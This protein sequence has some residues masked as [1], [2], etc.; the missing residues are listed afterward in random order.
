VLSKKKPHHYFALLTLIA[1][2]LSKEVALM[3][4]GLIFVVLLF[5]KKSFSK[6]SFIKSII[7][8][9][10]FA[11]IAGSYF[12]LRITVLNFNNTLNFYNSANIY[13]SH[14]LVRLYTFFT[15]FPSYLGLLIYPK[16]L[17]MERDSG[18]QIITSLNF[19]ILLSILL[20]VGAFCLAIWQRKRCPVILFSLL[21]ITI[22][23]IPTSGILPINGIF[24]EHF[25]FFPSVGFFLLFSYGCMELYKRVTGFSKEIVGI[26][27]LLGI[28]LLCLRTIARNREWHDPI[29][30]YNQTLSHVQ[31]PRAYN[32]LAMA[33]ADAGENQQA[34]TTYKKAISLS[35][36]YPESH[37]NLANTYVNLNNYS[38]AE[39]E[40]KNALKISPTFYL[41]Y[42]KLYG[43]YKSTNNTS[44]L[45]FVHDGLTTLGKYNPQFLT[46]L[47][48]L[49]GN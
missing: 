9:I 25:L 30:F 4:P 49:E 39:T 38:A 23:F 43:L 20:I 16:M 2:L 36:T 28:L 46:L 31:S 42:I 21:W 40:Y 7:Q 11:L 29:I 27:L 15:I 47:H 45:S 17:F 14:L 44:G 1:A 26:L 8:T 12:I 3:T 18:V 22:S 33:Y 13:S 34:V 5:S 24:Y 37:Y 35:D 32:N 41:A 6:H 10:P 48:Q 19:S